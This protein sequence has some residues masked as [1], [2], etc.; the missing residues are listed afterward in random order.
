[1]K[2][3]K[4]HQCAKISNIFWWHNRDS[5][6][7]RVPGPE[8]KNQP[9]QIL[10]CMNQTTDNNPQ[11]PIIVLLFSKLTKIYQSRSHVMRGIIC[12]WSLALKRASKLGLIWHAHFCLQ[13]SQFCIKTLI[14]TVKPSRM[15]FWPFCSI[16]PRTPSFFS[17]PVDFSPSKLHLPR[18]PPPA[19]LKLPTTFPHVYSTDCICPSSPDH[20]SFFCSSFSP[21]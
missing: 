21:A 10:I 14:C 6:S 20:C 7:S 12:H 15:L 11:A 4:S 8:Y 19:F 16:F 3:K 1:M 17:S 5:C 18:L 2:E 13:Y 9:S